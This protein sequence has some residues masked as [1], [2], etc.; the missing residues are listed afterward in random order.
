MRLKLRTTI[1]LA[2][3]SGLL[4]PV[5]V[6][7]MLTLRQQDFIQEQQFS[8]DHQRLAD[9]LA[10]GMQT[11]LWNF[12][13]DTGEAL[14]DSVSSDERVVSA[15]V[16]DDKTGVFL[17]RNHPERRKGRQY[18]IRRDISHDG[19]KIG[20]VTIEMDSGRL[21][22]AAAS[23][24]RILILTVIGQ[25]LFSLILIVTLLQAR[26]LSPLKRLM[27]QSERLASRDAGTPFIW[28]RGDEIGSLGNTLERTRQALQQ[29]FRELE[30][31]NRT[32]RHDIERRTMIEQELKRHRN[33]LEDLVNQRTAILAQRSQELA[34]SNTE[35]EQLAYVA[36]HDL[37]EPLRMIASYLQLLEKRYKDKLDADA[38]EFIAFAV[39]GAQ[40]MQAL[41]NDLLSYSRIGTKG[42]PF[43]PVDCEAVLDAVLRTLQIRIAETGARI[44][45]HP[46]PTVEGDGGQLAQL[47]QNLLTNAVKFH[48][49][50]TP[51]VEIRAE[52][53][54]ES[55][56]GCG[57]WR[58][59]VR[60]N[61]IGI[62]PEYFERIFVM[63][64]RLHGRDSYSGTGIGLAICKKIVERHG[65]RIRV[66]SE[67]G[68]GSIFLF[69]I[70][71]PRKKESNDEPTTGKLPN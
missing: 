52:P 3:A 31:K 40:R 22:A 54:P 49:Q 17:T 28:N 60:D 12:N 34:R 9:I 32:L 53:E 64:Q 35:L 39:D 5:S 55:M 42:K 68:K 56:S 44:E 51:L 13:L 70:P 46:L 41:I 30:T 2:V 16:F 24:R 19:E 65:G 29:L 71:I 58:F 27:R 69:T 20:V 18:T 38:Q 48:G 1:M 37:Q 21:D 25:L 59:S 33:H 62:A 66:E 61:G 4:L 6:S 11:S 15:R 10:V 47:F 43:R 14:L 45:R 67:P 63:F 50:R 57:F 8:S 36:S 7:T 26:L 23:Y